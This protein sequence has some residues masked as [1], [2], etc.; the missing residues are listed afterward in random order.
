VTSWPLLEEERALTGV[1]CLAFNR[2]LREMSGTVF[3]AGIL[4][5]GLGVK[6]S[7][8]SATISFRCD[9]SAILP[10]LQGSGRSAFGLPWKRQH[11]S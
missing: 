8:K 11:G 6:A 4:I 2:R 5:H 9:R 7:W 1:L 3:V 10:F